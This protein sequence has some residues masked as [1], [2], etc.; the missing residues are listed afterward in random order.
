MYHILTPE[1]LIGFVAIGDRF[2]RMTPY[3]RI[4]VNAEQDGCHGELWKGGTLCHKNHT[5]TP[6]AAGI[7]VL[8]KELSRYVLGSDGV[9][10]PRGSKFKVGTTVRLKDEEGIGEILGAPTY[11]VAVR[12]TPTSKAHSRHYPESS[13]EPADICEH[14]GAV[15]E[16]PRDMHET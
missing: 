11:Y 16:K 1:E 14:C 15:K 3:G 4:V 13:L 12:A 6:G 5:T 8:T 10:A 7:I 9:P 2:E